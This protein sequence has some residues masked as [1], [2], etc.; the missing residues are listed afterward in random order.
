M[1]RAG[2]PA[3]AKTAIDGSSGRCFTSRHSAFVRLPPLTVVLAIYFAIVFALPLVLPFN[4]PVVWLFLNLDINVL[5]FGIDYAGRASGDVTTF[6]LHQLIYAVIHF[7]RSILR[8]LGATTIGFIIKWIIPSDFPR[9]T[10]A[11]RTFWYEKSHTGKVPI[12]L[13]DIPS[14]CIAYFFIILPRNARRRY[15]GRKY[16]INYISS[17]Y[18]CKAG[19]Y[20]NCN[21]NYYKNSEFFDV[22]DIRCK[23]YPNVVVKGQT[24][25]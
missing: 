1:K 16:L 19:L 23:K 2:L 12:S 7:T 3:E 22:A 4:L 24:R 11:P 18:F 8:E 17:Y 13:W 5:Y 20:W 25:A 10:F 9:Y 15:C 14:K 6:R 21:I